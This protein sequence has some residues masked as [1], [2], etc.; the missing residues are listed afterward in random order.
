MINAAEC[1][2]IQA[3]HYY[4]IF[5][6]SPELDRRMMVDQ[7]ANRRRIGSLLSSLP[8]LRSLGYL[9]TLL[10]IQSFQA[11]VYRNV[12]TLRAVASQTSAII[13]LLKLERVM[14]AMTRFFSRC[15]PRL[16][17]ALVICEVLA[18]RPQ[19]ALH[20]SSGYVEHLVLWV[21]LES[22]T[23][24]LLCYLLQCCLFMPDLF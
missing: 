16:E 18:L 7:V 8:A 11:A 10:L 14:M 24:R 6:L 9:K 15:T 17:F 13:L 19:V 20:A 22:F 21:G 3:V 4:R 2:V 23:Y 12:W 1:A 5:V